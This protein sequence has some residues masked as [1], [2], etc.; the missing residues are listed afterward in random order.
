MIASRRRS[1]KLLE[2]EKTKGY[3]PIDRFWPDYRHA[4]PGDACF[5]TTIE[6]AN[7]ASCGSGRHR[8]VA[9]AGDFFGKPRVHPA[10]VF[11][12]NP[13]LANHAFDLA[14]GGF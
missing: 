5:V 4:V 3:L 11:P 2:N 13:H 7:R 14:I 6:R 10:R 8:G 1:G 9:V 12:P